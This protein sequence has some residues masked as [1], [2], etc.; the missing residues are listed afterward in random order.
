MEF[1][2]DYPL[3]PW[4]TFKVGGPARWYCRPASREELAEAF[5]FAARED[6]P[7]FCMGRGSNLLV[8]DDGW[9]GLVIHLAGLDQVR[10]EGERFVC[11][12]GAAVT[13]VT[14]SAVRAGLSGLEFAGGLPG[15]IG[16]AVFMNARAYGGELSGI[17][18]RV[19]VMDPAGAVRT[20]DNRE[21]EYG[22]KHSRLMTRPET[23]FEVVLRLTPGDPEEIRR[24]TEENREKRV[25]MGQFTFPNAGCVFKNDYTTG[26]PSGK[27]I[28]ECGL[29][30][31]RVGDAEVFPKHGNFI[32]NRG[33]ASAVEIRA[34]IEEVRET[35]LRMRGIRLEE[36]LRYLG[37]PETAPRA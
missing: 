18:E 14:D 10:Q 5:A 35:V 3:A 22:Y 34:L 23:A 33:R 17:V 2:P 24:R 32:I 13:A 28:D 27:L 21:M 31:R 30:G 8:H 26:I 9:P 1:L 11:G 15:S 4:T 37:F 25:A 12:A 29:L 16:G 6:L 36:E 7:C 19:L 20:L